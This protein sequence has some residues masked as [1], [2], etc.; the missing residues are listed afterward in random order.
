MVQ[1]RTEQRNGSGRQALGSGHDGSAER[2][3]AARRVAS[4]RNTLP[5]CRERPADSNDIVQCSRK[6]VLWRLA[7]VHRDDAQTAG[8]KAC[9]DR[10]RHCCA[11]QHVAAAVCVD[12]RRRDRRRRWT[13]DQALHTA[14]CLTLV[15]HL[16][17]V[18]FAPQLIGRRPPACDRRVIGQVGHPDRHRRLAS[19]LVG[20]GFG[21]QSVPTKERCRFSV[22]VHDDPSAALARQQ[23]CDDGLEPVLMHGD[24]GHGF[25][26]V[27]HREEVAVEPGLALVEVMAAAAHA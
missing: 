27:R 17:V 23:C 10:D 12:D 19:G 26:A 20:D 5:A 24:R 4:E 9:S 13:R 18:L 21:R 2:K 8:C 22:G 16:W 25:C 7:V 6:L 3:R 14:D 11:A 1:Q 15:R